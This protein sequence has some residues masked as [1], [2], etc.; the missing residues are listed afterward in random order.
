MSAVEGIK[1]VLCVCLCVC[2]HS[3]KRLPN[4]PFI[5]ISDRLVS[6]SWRSPRGPMLSFYIFGHEKWLG[7]H[8][9]GGPL[10]AQAFPFTL[11]LSCILKSKWKLCAEG[12]VW[13]KCPQLP[14]GGTE[15]PQSRDDISVISKQ[16]LMFLPFRYPIHSSFKD[17]LY[18][19]FG[20]DLL[21]LTV[22]VWNIVG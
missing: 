5:N 8:D 18:S 20:P 11:V 12:F 17:V 21:C 6:V 15:I 16:Y 4:P 19:M 2:L 22:A 14:C 7:G 9:A 13:N 3:Q 10:N 1:S